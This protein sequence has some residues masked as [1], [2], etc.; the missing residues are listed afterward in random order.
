MV[1]LLILALPLLVYYMLFCISANGGA[2]F[3]PR[4][5]SDLTRMISRA[6]APTAAAALIYGAWFLLQVLLQ[7]YAPGK[8]VEGTPLEDGSR[9]KY[10][11][12]GWFSW[13][14][15]WALIGLLVVSGTL[16][17]TLLYD[18][19]FALLTIVNLFT[20][21]FCIYLYLHGK[22]TDKRAPRTGNWLYDYWMGTALNPRARDFDLKLFCESRPGLILWVAINLSL[23][24]KQYELYGR[25]SA[26]MI[27]VCLFHFWYIADYFF[28]E[29]AILTTWDIKH[30][31][32]GFMLCW[33]DLV[34]VPFTY[35]LQAYYLLHHP[36]DLP[37][38]AIVAIVALNF[39]GFAIFR[40]AN[41]QKHHFRTHPERPVWGKPAEYIST[42]RGTLLLTSGWW[43][44]S[45]H[46]N[47]F[48][49]LMMGLAWCLPT[50]F[51]HPLP[52]FYIAYFT[53]LLVH[54]ERRDHAMCQAKYGRDW[55]L[56]CRKVRWRIVPGLY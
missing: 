54:R 8:I 12:N 37:V 39:T 52:Y 1:A 28:H 55:D 48:G 38:W 21:A 14:F 35:T 30:E 9:L 31:K 49:D 19:F 33:G 44:L 32:F 36:V 45:R 24:A 56:Y 10:K 2:L 41:I 13:W 34:W 53:I 47:Y 46:M 51:A 23:A 50:G 15:T 29:P 11:M 26:A 27:L 6:A 18:H 43:G 4:S 20:V 22:A 40:G 3:L 25:V 7:I 42:G 17:P 5:M 16:K